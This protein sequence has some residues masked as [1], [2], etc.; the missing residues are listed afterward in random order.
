MPKIETEIFIAAPLLTVY[1][2]AKDF[3][4]FPEFC[5]DVE[6]VH[7]IDRT[8][9]GY[10]SDWVGVVAKLN[11]KLQ[12][13]ELDEWDDA[14]HT[15]T[16]RAISG[17][18]EKYDGLWTFHEQDGGTRMHMQLECDVNVPMIGAIIKGLIG[19]L[20]KANIDHMFEGI[21]RRSLGEV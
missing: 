10:T 9:T 3:E 1:G 14:T 11:R 17:D 18:W 15:C 7:I 6:S 20:A 13:R 4:R 12:W 19:K 16:Y 5:A 8:E 2:V 21:R